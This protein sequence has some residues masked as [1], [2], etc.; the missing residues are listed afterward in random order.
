MNSERAVHA[1]F[2]T[3][4]VFRSLTAAV[5][6]VS[7]LG[8]SLSASASGRPACYSRAEHAAEQAIR[9]HTELMVIGLTCQSVA[10]A[11]N[12]FGKYQDFT[13][14]H[15]AFIS[16]QEKVLI[17]HF[18]KTARGN[19]TRAFD[20]FRT[21]L[22]NEISRRSA[23]VGTNIYCWNYVDRAKAAL[24]LTRDDVK[25]LTGDEKGAALLHL[26]SKPLCD[27]K[28]VSGPDPVF[29]VAAA[30]PPAPRT[31]AKPAAAAKPADAKPKP[32]PT[33]ASAK[34]PT[35]PAAKPAAKPAPEKVAANFQR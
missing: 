24:Q 13:I 4:R 16:D 29:D 30:T 22:A 5:A 33:P 8:F 28:V 35:K 23:I 20:S 15:R 9:M 12:P 3:G 31:D 11:E 14:K 34:A 26:S 10:A 27:V 1:R 7:V 17:E 18:R 2:A 6:A 21:E 19:P 25:T 32:A